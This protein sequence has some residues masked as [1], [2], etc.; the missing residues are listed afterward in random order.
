LTSQQPYQEL[1]AVQRAKE[2]VEQENIEIKR[3]LAN[4]I[5]ELQPLLGNSM[6][7]HLD[8]NKSLMLTDYHSIRS[9]SLIRVPISDVCSVCAKCRSTPGTNEC[10]QCLNT[11][12]CPVSQQHGYWLA[13]LAECW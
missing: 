10:P 7:T 8:I 1:L 3:R 12:K 4:I 6:L 2:A 13:E 11:W 5:G 9:Q